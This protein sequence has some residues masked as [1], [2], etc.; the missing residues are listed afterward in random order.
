MAAGTERLIRDYIPNVRHMTLATVDPEL[1]ALA[2]ELD[3]VVRDDL[4]L[5]FRSLATRRHVL[6]I[7]QDPRVTG[8]IVQQHELGERP[9]GVF[10]V[11]TV[12]LVG[13]HEEQVAWA[14]LFAAQ[15]GA[16]AQDAMA[17]AAGGGPQFY[18]I[19]VT[20][21]GYYGADG[22]RQTLVLPWGQGV[23]NQ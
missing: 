22:N 14:E 17:R 19:D 13:A 5:C 16:D 15:Q 21:W 1:G 7:Q 6:H 11:G 8:T 23:Q 4:T 10:F 3:F 2:T 20:R 18:Q 9:E 12:A